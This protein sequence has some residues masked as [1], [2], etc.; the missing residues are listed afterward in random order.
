MKVDS[1]KLIRQMR[2]LPDVSRAHIIKAVAKSV[3]EGASVARTLAPDTTGET[4]DAITTVYRE[5]G[6]VAEIV[7]IDSDAPQVDKNRAYSIEHGR[8]KGD[9]GTTEGYHHVH[10]TRQYLGKRF[11]GRI[12]RAINKAAKEVARG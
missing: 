5:G 10:R 4:R 8:K 11:K 12:R 2:K 7:V 1:K 3:E 6:M 9:R